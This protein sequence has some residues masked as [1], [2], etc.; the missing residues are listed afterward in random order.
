VKWHE[1]AAKNANIADAASKLLNDPYL[2]PQAR[3]K[4]T[5]VVDKYRVDS[6]VPEDPARTNSA[7]AKAIDKLPRSLQIPLLAEL[8]VGPEGFRAGLP[9]LLFTGVAVGTDIASGK[10]PGKTV[11]TSIGSTVAG[12]IGAG[13][14]S[15]FGG[16]PILV[17]VGGTVIGNVVATGLGWVYDGIASGENPSYTTPN[18]QPRTPPFSR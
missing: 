6:W 4:M 17:T 10:D 15:T 3:E 5:G 14:I 13:V 16:G 1:L 7:A 8:K 2:T 18:G 11:G 12:V 9:G